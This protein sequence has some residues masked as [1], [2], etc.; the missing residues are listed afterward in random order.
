MSK[1][2]HHFNDTCVSKA[3]THRSLYRIVSNTWYAVPWLRELVAGLPPRR[4]G[5]ASGSVH[6]R[7]MVDKVALGQ[8]FLRVLR[9]SPVS[10]IPPGLHTHISS[11]GWTIGPLVATIQRHSLIPW[12]NNNK[13]LINSPEFLINCPWF[14]NN[15]WPPLY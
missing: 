6:V 9:F 1:N 12:N 14:L 13:H 3:L 7:F 5:F 10:I 2:T 15:G 4:P 8:V 11:R